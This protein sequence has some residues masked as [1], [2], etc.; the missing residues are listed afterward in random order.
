M[1]FRKRFFEKFHL[2][3]GPYYFR[4]AND[5]KF[6]K[7][8][9]LSKPQTTG[10]DSANI[11]SRKTYAGVKF[12]LHLDNRNSEIFPTRGVLWDNH[13]L[14][15]AGIG[16]SHNFSKYSSDMTLYISKNNSKLVGIF[17]AGISRI[18][19]KHY[20]FFQAITFG[21]NNLKGF[22]NNRYQ[23]TRATY[24][25]LELRAKLFDIDSY[26]LSGPFGLTA[27]YDIGRVRVQGEGS[28]KFHSAVGGGF[29]FVPFN[30]FVITASAGYAAGDRVLNFSIGTKINLN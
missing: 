18:L 9:I 26:I 25:S 16:N 20:E 14:Y 30:L 27:F 13:F 15:A 5:Y 8:N 7:G 6:T 11:F 3:F 21:N 1:L 17:K 29:Y 10:L 4:Y 23:G 12:N 19:S 22:R 24:G 28:K 2:M